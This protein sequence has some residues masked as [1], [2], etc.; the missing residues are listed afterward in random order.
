MTPLNIEKTVV[1][2][3]SRTLKANWTTEK[4][5]DLASE[6]Y[7]ELAKILQEELDREILNET[8]KQ[9]LRLKGWTEVTPH[10]DV[11]TE[12]CNAYIKKPYNKF[13]Q[14]WYFSDERDATLFTLKWSSP[15]HD[16]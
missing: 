7:D 11:D 14:H 8:L 12:W 10:T 5:Q 4:L 6:I 15:R 13:G 9:Q 1:E 3:K 16:R 2:A